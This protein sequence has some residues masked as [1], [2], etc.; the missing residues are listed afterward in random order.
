MIKKSKL[1]PHLNI[2]F[3]FG[4][5]FTIVYLLSWGQ[6]GSVLN[7]FFIHQRI[8][9]VLILFL[10]I[11][12]VS[13]FG[14]YLYLQKNRSKFYHSNS[15]RI[16][17]PYLLITF[18]FAVFVLR[19]FGPY[20]ELKKIESYESIFEIDVPEEIYVSSSPQSFDD[21]AGRLLSVSF[22]TLDSS[23]FLSDLDLEHGWMIMKD[24]D[25]LDEID[26]SIVQNLGNNPLDFSKT[27]FK[28]V[29]ITKGE[30]P[31]VYLASFQEDKNIL[32]FIEVYK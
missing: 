13:F 28:R 2:Y 19:P 32:S 6:Y 29:V 20:L 11:Y 23:D 5:V 24:M 1:W 21:S 17:T 15:W 18:V 12:A 8:I 31:I 3:S 10:V 16:L 9:V 14:G 27:R 26:G 4:L 7:N 22:H 30:H 25:N